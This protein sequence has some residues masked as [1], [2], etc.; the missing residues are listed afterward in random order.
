[1][2]DLATSLALVLTQMASLTLCA[3]WATDGFWLQAGNSMTAQQRDVRLFRFAAG[4]ERG[5]HVFSGGASDPGMATLSLIEDSF[6]DLVELNAG[7]HDM[8]FSIDDVT[9]IF[10]EESN[11]RVGVGN[12]D[13]DYLLDVSGDLGIQALNPELVIN[14]TTGSSSAVIR[15]PNDGTTNASI[16]VGSTGMSLKGGVVGAH[17]S[18]AMNLAVNGKVTLARSLNLNEGNPTNLALQV[19]SDEALWYNDDYFSWGFGGSWNRFA[20]PIRIGDGT[21]PAPGIDLDVQG[22]V[23]LSGE[24][25][26]AS[27][28]R[29]KRDMEYILDPLHTI[30]QLQPKTYQFRTEQY[31]AMKLP[32]GKRFGLIAQ[33]VEEILPDLVS[34]GSEV[35]D[36]LGNAFAVKS[37]NYQEL[38]PLL[39]AA[40]QELNTN[41]EQQKK[42]IAEQARE[43]RH[44]QDIL[45]SK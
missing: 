42:I 40:V 8:R 10:I 28:S 4:A 5:Y 21:Q 19:R 32:A 27:D 15:F 37:V 3:Q 43:I 17:L 30:C 39:V 12:N 38:I 33:E 9:R 1:M 2:K 25:T 36:E 18:N 29:L 35:H 14:R 20:R 22:N 34:I 45:D 44:L 24:L 11:G 16:S 13:P 26:A 41:I 7:G 31:A 6:N 23:N